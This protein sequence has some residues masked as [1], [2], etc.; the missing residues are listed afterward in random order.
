M[1]VEPMRHSAEGCIN[2][3]HN[4]SIRLGLPAGPI[5]IFCNRFYWTWVDKRSKDFKN[6]KQWSSNPTSSRGDLSSWARKQSASCGGWK[7]QDDSISGKHPL[8]IIANTK[9]LC[10]KCK[11]LTRQRRAI[12]FHQRRSCS[13][14]RGRPRKK[15][16][17]NNS[18]EVSG[19]G[20][21]YQMEDKPQDGEGSLRQHGC[22]AGASRLLEET[23]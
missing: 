19:D 7:E 9:W 21:G 13:G 18:L 3:A 16:W 10:N 11:F 17:I 6:R 15:N 2:H 12:W 4:E 23:R 5:N 8:Q 14:F 1:K 20:D 22:P